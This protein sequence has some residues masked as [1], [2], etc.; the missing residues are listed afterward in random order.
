MEVLDAG[1][2][3]KLRHVEGEYFETLTFIKRNSGD[4]RH[5][6]QYAG[7]NTQEVLRALIDR[8]KYLAEQ[9]DCNETRDALHYL[10]MTLF[11]YEARALRRKLGK[12]NRV[13]GEHV[14]LTKGHG[15]EPDIPFTYHHIEYRGV[16]VDGHIKIT[17]EEAAWMAERGWELPPT[18]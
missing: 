14:T 10:R 16:G 17:E 6:I 18:I 12:V 4:M 1:H 7:T 8:T 13:G 3:Y 15:D 5:A 9:V 11:V 2:T